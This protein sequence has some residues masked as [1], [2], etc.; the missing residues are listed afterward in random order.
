LAEY[1]L[2]LHAPKQ[3]NTSPVEVLLIVVAPDTLMS[4]AAVAPL[5]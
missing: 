2:P 5:M 3:F 4:F 1:Q